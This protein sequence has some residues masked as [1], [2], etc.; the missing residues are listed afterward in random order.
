MSFSSC[1]WA[2]TTVVIIIAITDPLL[3]GRYQRN[4]HRH[5]LHRRSFHLDISQ[6]RGFWFAPQTSPVFWCCQ[7]F[8]PTF[9]SASLS[10]Y[11][12]LHYF[13][14]LLILMAALRNSATESWEY[15]KTIAF[16][17]IDQVAAVAVLYLSEETRFRSLSL[18]FLSTA[19]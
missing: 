2:A 11:F 12:S 16:S 17:L 13:L 6:T 3:L 8:A 1:T 4:R 18:I 14:S 5:L 7:V 15:D 19:S 10:R 9:V